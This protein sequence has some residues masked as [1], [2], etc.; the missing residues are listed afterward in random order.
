MRSRI[1]RTTI[2]FAFLIVALLF[3]FAIGY[4]AT[5]QIAD[6][7][8]WLVHT[9]TV[10]GSL[11]SLELNLRKS[12]G[13]VQNLLRTGRPEYLAAY[14]RTASDVNNQIELLRDLTSDNPS[15]AVL[16]LSFT[17]SAKL[18]DVSA[19]VLELTQVSFIKQVDL[20][21]LMK[22]YPDLALYFA[23]ELGL[24]YASLCQ[25]LSTIGLQRS[26][27]SRLAQLLA[28][29]IENESPEQG[30]LQIEC[31]L[32]HEV[33]AQ[34]IGTSRETVTRLLHDLRAKHIATIQ[35][36]LLTTKNARALRALV[37]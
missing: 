36:N 1:S 22:D 29:W 13:G 31:S 19:E 10:L 17:V 23:K 24:E 26:A 33:I 18:H 21:Q 2:V 4:R 16:G 6:G 8:N 32:T 5:F 34:L 15:G 27:M 11:D 37:S 35:N 12:E 9:Y 14:E 7:E 28:S 3:S 30:E 20:L 25:E